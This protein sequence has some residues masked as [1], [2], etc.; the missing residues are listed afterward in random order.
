MVIVD[1]LFLLNLIWKSM[2]LFCVSCAKKMAK[3]VI[4]F[5][6]LHFFAT[7]IWCSFSPI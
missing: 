5:V 6:F 7:N 4:T 3:M 2:V 1:E